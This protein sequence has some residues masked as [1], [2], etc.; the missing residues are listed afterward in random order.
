MDGAFSIEA[1]LVGGQNV[2]RFLGSHVSMNRNE[3]IPEA[4]RFFLKKR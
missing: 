3:C 2:G 4:T 1:Y